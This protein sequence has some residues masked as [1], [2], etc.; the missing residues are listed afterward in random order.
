MRMNP[1]LAFQGNCEEA[2]RFYQQAI[3]GDLVALVRF[4]ETPM[5]ANAP[6]D[7][8]DRIA[9]ARLVVGEATLMGSDCG[10]G[11]YEAPGGT[12]TMLGVD[13]PEEA[14]RVFAALSEGGAIVMPLE[15]TFFAHRFAVFK[16][17]FG[18]P[19]MLVCEKQMAEGCP[20][21]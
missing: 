11:H 14:E 20:A 2:F 8:H 13:T 4:G 19:W 10:P 16:D 12:A 18:I 9:H 1:H 17:R 21:A 15:E 3:G 5:A 7:L 6:A